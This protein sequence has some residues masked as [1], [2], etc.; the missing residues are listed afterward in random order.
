MTAIGA[1]VTD[2]D[3]DRPFS[4]RSPVQRDCQ[5]AVIGAPPELGRRGQPEAHLGTGPDSFGD[6]M[7]DKEILEESGLGI[8][9][10]NSIEELKGYAD[11]V[12]DNIADDGVFN[13]LVKFDFINT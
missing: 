13:V 7:N 11:Y 12:T 4:P 9:M 8:A 3:T 2:L 6:S 10:G 5:A 1:F